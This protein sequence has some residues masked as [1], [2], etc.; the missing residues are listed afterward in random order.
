NTSTVR[1]AL[2]AGI[3]NV[4]NTLLRAGLGQDIPAFPSVALGAFE[5]TLKD[6]TSAYTAFSNGGQRLHPTIITEVRNASGRIVF[7]ST[8][9]RLR[10]LTPEATRTTDAILADVV[11][12]GTAG[13]ARRLGLTRRAAG[14]TGT[15]DESRDAWF[16]GYVRSL[17]C[18][19]W[20]GLD[21]PKSIM[22]GGYG[23]TLALPIWVDFMESAPPARYPD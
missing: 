4:V 18:G 16:I 19:V 21:Q 10:F 11:T 13:S 22:P 8:E 17:T 9:A 20:V 14:K 3:N 1:V 6:L 15:T 5:T 12:R 7:K 23:S 2:R